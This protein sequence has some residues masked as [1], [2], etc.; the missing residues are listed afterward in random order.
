MNINNDENLPYKKKTQSNVSKSKNKSKHKH[1]YKECLCEYSFEKY[2]GLPSIYNMRYCTIC[3][4]LDSSQYHDTIKEWNSSFNQYVYRALSNEEKLEKYKDLPYI[5]I[6]N[7]LQKY[8]PLTIDK[9]K[10]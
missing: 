3:G 1:I 8:I 6:N 2:K 9:E 10:E 5:K 4:K 7:L